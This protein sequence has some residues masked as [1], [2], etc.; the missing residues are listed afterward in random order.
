MASPGRQLLPLR[1]PRIAARLNHLEHP[2][3]SF[4]RN[5]RLVVQNAGDGRYRHAAGLCNVNDRRLTQ[6]L[7]ERIPHQLTGSTSY[8]PVVSPN[9]V[10]CSA[11]SVNNNQDSY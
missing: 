4:L 11:Q 6:L 3:A 5:V 9:N 2:S 10:A 8:R 1:L 7:H